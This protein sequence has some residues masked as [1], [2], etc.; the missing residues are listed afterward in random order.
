MGTKTEADE[1]SYTVPYHV[2]ATRR[3]STIQAARQ[4]AR[5]KRKRAD[6]DPIVHVVL[7]WPQDTDDQLP[8]EHC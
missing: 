7:E 8:L 1:F 5:R 2:W 4:S 3:A 6:G